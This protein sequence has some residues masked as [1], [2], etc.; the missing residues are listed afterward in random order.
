M[1]YIIFFVFN[2]KISLFI[3]IEDDRRVRILTN[4]AIDNNTLGYTFIVYCVE[5][6]NMLDTY[7]LIYFAVDSNGI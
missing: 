7:G 4:N 3:W 2:Y 1:Y 6:P 5:N